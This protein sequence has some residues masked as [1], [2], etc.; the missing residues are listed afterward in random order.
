MWEAATEH[1][2]GFER[3]FHVLQGLVIRGVGATYLSKLLR[4][5]VEFI[6]LRLDLLELLVVPFLLELLIDA[7]LDSFLCSWLLLRVLGYLRLFR[8]LPA[9][10]LWLAGVRRR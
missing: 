6:D 4:L 5:L 7:S 3:G 1:L 2:H 10:F 9:L 8:G